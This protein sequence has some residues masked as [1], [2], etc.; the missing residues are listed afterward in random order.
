MVASSSL[1][2]NY[3][4]AIN[5]NYNKVVLGIS[6]SIIIIYIRSCGY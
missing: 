1:I 6:I 4:L 3:Y 5:Y 2:S